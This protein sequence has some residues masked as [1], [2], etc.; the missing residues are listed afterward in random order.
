MP[1]TEAGRKRLS[2][3]AKARER[4]PSGRFLPVGRKYVYL[5]H[6]LNPASPRRMPSHE[7]WIHIRVSLYSPEKKYTKEDFRRIADRT[8]AEKA[9]DYMI[10]RGSR[11]KFESFEELRISRKQARLEGLADEKPHIEVYQGK[12]GG[13]RNT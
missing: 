7:K 5:M 1:L 13:L 3:L 12:G 10:P 6:Y 4:A 2:E 9:P 11:D 8:K